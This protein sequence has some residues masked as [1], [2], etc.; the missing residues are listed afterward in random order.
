[1]FVYVLRVRRVQ[2]R[3]TPLYK[4][5]T[6]AHVTH[7][8]KFVYKF[9]IPLYK[10][11]T[12]A[13]VTHMYKL[14]TQTHV[15]HLHTSARNAWTHKHTQV[16]KH[17]DTQA[18]PT[19]RHTDARNTYTH[20]HKGNAN[21]EVHKDMDLKVNK[22]RTSMVHENVVVAPEEGRAAD[23]VLR[24]TPELVHPALG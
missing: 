18:H 13:H 5:C 10:F 14:S 19:H 24:V 20:R 12:Q 8:Y 3:N 4:F 1:L 21:R 6:Q 7:M 17:I 23:P 11:C 9:V 22:R 15:T 16:V 2:V